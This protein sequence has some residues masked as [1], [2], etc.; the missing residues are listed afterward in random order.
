MQEPKFIK[1]G[2]LYLDEQMEVWRLKPDAP[3]WAKKE[4]EEYNASINPEPDEQGV[5]TQV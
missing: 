5:I 4:Y 2:W 3:D 1:E